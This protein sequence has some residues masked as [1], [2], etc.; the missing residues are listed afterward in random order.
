MVYSAAM[1]AITRRKTR[2][3]DYATITKTVHN[4]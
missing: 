2:I 1:H 3:N 4:D